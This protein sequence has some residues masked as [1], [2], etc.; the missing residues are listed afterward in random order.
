MIIEK[1]KEHIR[2]NLGLSV[3]GFLALLMAVW[4]VGCESEVM[5]PISETMVTRAELGIEY[6]AVIQE[7]VLAETNLDKQDAIKEKM[8]EVAFTLAEGGTLNPVGIATSLL[9][10]LGIG[11]VVDN[12]IKD[13]IIKTKTVA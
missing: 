9:S 7:I 13:R 6:D 3:A 1:I 2:H 8:T 5:S 12:K 10:I 11:A 4:F